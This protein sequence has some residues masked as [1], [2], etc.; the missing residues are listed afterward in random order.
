MQVHNDFPHI[1]CH[2]LHTLKNVIFS[3]VFWTTFMFPPNMFCDF[4]L[5]MI[6]AVKMLRH[7]LHHIY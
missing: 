7:L 1:W 5:C 4:C 3:A 6:A 2:V